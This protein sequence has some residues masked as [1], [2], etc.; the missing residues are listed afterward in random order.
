VRDSLDTSTGEHVQKSLVL[1]VE[2]EKPIAEVL[3]FIVEDAGYEVAVAAHGS[4]ALELVNGGERP[5]LL[6]TDLMMPKMD[7]ASLIRALRSSLGSHMPPVV[8]MT[9]A[10][11]QHAEQADADEILDKPFD[12]YT[13]ES[14]LHRLLP[15]H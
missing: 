8:L 13:V 5:D 1:I 7:G 10:G 12:L 15:H 9:A 3:A 6:I 11:P 14:L 4:E 2:D